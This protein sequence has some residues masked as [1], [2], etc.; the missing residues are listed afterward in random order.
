MHQT[1]VP[2]RLPNELSAM[3]KSRYP[4][5]L[6]GEQ[7]GRWGAFEAQTIA[8][9]QVRR[10]VRRTVGEPGVANTRAEWDVGRTTIGSHSGGFRGQTEKEP[11]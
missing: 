3:L 11:Y 4:C 8:S 5:W 9:I 6:A 1:G 2:T 7:V 10:E